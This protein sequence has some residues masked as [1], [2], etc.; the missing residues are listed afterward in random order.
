MR[1]ISAN[2]IGEEGGAGDC[3]LLHADGI[4]PSAALGADIKPWFSVGRTTEV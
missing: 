2:E 1:P 3:H 4:A